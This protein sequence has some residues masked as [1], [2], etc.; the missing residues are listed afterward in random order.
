M[1]KKIYII[2]LL[3]SFLSIGF[4]SIN[5]SNTIS[6]LIPSDIKNDVNAN[7]Q[8]QKTTDILPQNSNQQI[9]KDKI[10]NQESS[11]SFIENLFYQRLIIQNETKININNMLYI[12]PL[13]EETKNTENY[14]SQSND[15]N[16]DLNQQNKTN[17]SN[18]PQSSEQTINNSSPL[19]QYGYNIFNKTFNN[20]NIDNLPAND[21]Y[22]LGP[23]DTI[24][25]SL[26]GK[27]E[28]QFNLTLDKEGNIFIPEIGNLNLNKLKFSQAKKLIQNA[29]TS[30]YVNFQL[31]IT[32]N[33]FKSIKV[34]VLGEVT[35]PGSYLL[36]SFSSML[37]ALYQANGPE[38]MG[39]LRN[40]KLIR[41]KKTIYTLD[42]Y[43]YLMRGDSTNDVE[44]KD[45]DIIFVSTIGN[46]VAIQGLVKRP[47]IYEL[48]GRTSVYDII[49][50]AGGLAPSSYYKLIQVERIKNGQAKVML[51]LKF[52]SLKEQVHSLQA[53]YVQDGDVV[54]ILPISEEI[55][56][57]VSIEGNIERPGNYQF[58]PGLTLEKLI[59]M[60]DG[61]ATDSYLKRVEIYRYI[62]KDNRKIIAIDYSQPEG[63]NFLLTDW[64]IVK[65]YSKFDVTGKQYVYIEGA[66]KKPGV[67]K[68]LKNM[69]A[70][71][72]L[73]LAQ[74][75]TFAKLNAVELYRQEPDKL[76]TIYTINMRVITKNPSSTSNILLM[77]GDRLVIR[78]EYG[79]KKPN[80]VEISGEVNYP[81]TY[82]IMEEEK[83][84]SLIERA[85]GYTP[86]AF[87][88]GA[89]FTRQSIK[90]QEQKAEI[91]ILG[92]E[93]KRL[94]YDQSIANIQNRDTIQEAIAYLT[95]Q[96]DIN[97]GRLVINLQ[98]LNK[99][100]NS[101][102]DIYLENNDSLY[103]PPIPCSIQI[104]GGVRNPS[105]VT[106][107][108]NMN[109][110]YYIDLCGGVTDYAD[111]SNIL[112]MRANGNVSRDYQHIQIGDVIY[113]P[114]KIKKEIDWVQVIV[115]S[116]AT[117]AQI[118]TSIAIIK[119][120]FVK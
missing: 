61:L 48:N 111:K 18:T 6:N 86:R 26:W 92:T 108:E 117:V 7:I 50:F 1:L 116:S 14:L 60:A 110:D 79:N 113:V 103:I 22:I 19:Y 76:P 10:K 96:I 78:N 72:L 101:K 73:F 90:N 80:K 25:I 2:L 118:L 47:A 24:S 34:F 91:A 100:I 82:Y 98:P 53:F 41:N 43:R 112:I 11:L 64:D 70:L 13:K 85:G 89:I 51:D 42:L 107:V 62:S 120:L 45:N 35:N 20:A 106:Y 81:G 52:N 31:S 46:V 94:L 114:E 29:L 71:D 32:L 54:S 87:L 109:T 63:K 17:V 15:S 16:L 55:K 38:K 57:L 88:F 93:Q 3:I 30:K 8:Q 44:L 115:Q 66:V 37:I 119:T 28:K 102:D 12:K 23:N 65:I 33:S 9:I 5:Y 56:N 99:F 95:K 59:K 49:N 105:A 21:N 4:F 75:D 97:S 58:K 40:I 84:S 39:S 77:E 27:I 74:L 67:Y 68:L 69:R 83:L 104:V 36:S